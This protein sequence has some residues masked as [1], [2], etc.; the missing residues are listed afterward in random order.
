MNNTNDI[1]IKLIIHKNKY[2]VNFLLLYKL[3]LLSDNGM[4]FFYLLSV[5]LEN[6]SITVK[7]KIYSFY[8]ILVKLIWM[9]D[10]LK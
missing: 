8:F 9:I 2:P 7:L 10:L 5:S 6:L 3:L 4:I 1:N